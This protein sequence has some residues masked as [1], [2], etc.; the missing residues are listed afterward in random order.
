MQ[1]G[2]LATTATDW[3]SI[4]PHRYNLSAICPWWHILDVEASFFELQAQPF[5]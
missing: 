5:L 2:D 3:R 1:I 4:A